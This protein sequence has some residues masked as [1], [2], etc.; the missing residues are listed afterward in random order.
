M[1]VICQFCRKKIVGFNG[2]NCVK[3]NEYEKVWNK[4]IRKKV[5]RG[6]SV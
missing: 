2:C 5:R 3:S 1:V 6:I 4:G